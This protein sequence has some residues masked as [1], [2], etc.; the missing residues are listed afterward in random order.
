MGYCEGCIVK[1]LGVKKGAK[2]LCMGSL[3]SV[4]VPFN[5]LHCMLL[6]VLQF[7][8]RFKQCILHI[9]VFYESLKTFSVFC[10]NCTVNYIC[11]NCE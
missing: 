8:Q 5:F 7:M 3:M 4:A 1:H 6:S 10:E 9:R 11:T 2:L